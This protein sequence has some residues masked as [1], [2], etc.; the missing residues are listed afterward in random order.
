M[1]CDRKYLLKL[2]VIILTVTILF[3]P[4]EVM[5]QRKKSPGGVTG[6]A[7]LSPGSW[8]NQRSSQ[9][10]RHARDCSPRIWRCSRNAGRIGGAV[11]SSHGPTRRSDAAVRN[12]G[13]IIK[14]RVS[15]W[16]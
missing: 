3:G 8:S 16:S 14:T 7:R 1:F 5:A 9:S 12:R 11:R 2:C 10:V 13:H 4:S 15:C 6:G